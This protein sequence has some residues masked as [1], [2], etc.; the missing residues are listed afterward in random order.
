MT[1]VVL[2]AVATVDP[3][4]TMKEAKRRELKAA[5]VARSCEDMEPLR[6]AI[7]EAR[8]VN[9]RKKDIIE[10][11][12]ILKDLE[13]EMQPMA[14]TDVPR[15]DM[16]ALQACTSREE[17]VSKLI[18]LMHL[19]AQDG[20]RSEVL[21]EFH[22]HNFMFCQKSDFCPE[23]AS[24]FL[25]MMRVLHTQAVVAA[26]ADES[27]ARALLEKLLTRHS[28]QLPPFSVGVFTEKE[29][30]N[31]RDYTNRTFFR[32]YTM[33]VFMYLQKQ[34]VIVHRDDPRVVPQ[35]PAAG[36]LH[37]TFEVDPSEVPELQEFLDGGQAEP[38][39]F[40]EQAP[41]AKPPKKKS[42]KNSHRE[43]A[44]LAA[45]DEAMQAHFGDL[46]GK[47]KLPF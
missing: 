40:A 42:L 47:L 39:E 32:H 5:M 2:E 10:A 37:K 44:V 25:S 31:I 46:D 20:L 36:A 22:F 30:Q 18:K 26:K 15:A 8:E 19:S 41:K 28:R 4:Q 6:I 23:K 1:E 29:V 16:E 17:A 43:E 34:D 11:E 13:V 24:A 45:M 33:F 7:E 12:K 21:A 14:F 3:D 38:E 27:Q 35:V 9:L